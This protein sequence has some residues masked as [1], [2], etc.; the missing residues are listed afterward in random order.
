[1]NPYQK[2][3]AKAWWLILLAY[4]GATCWC[5]SHLSKFTVEAGTDVLLNEDDPDLAYYNE[6][7]TWWEYDEYIIVCCSRKSG[8]FNR[9]AL[10]RFNALCKDLQALPY[11]KTDGVTSITTIPLLR[12]KPPRGFLPDV[13]RMFDPKTREYNKDVD[14]A[15]AEKELLAHT[16]ALGNLISKN[17]QDVS[18]I[19]YLKLPE[20]INK[21]EPR[22]QRLMI[23]HKKKETTP[24]RRLAIEREL[25]EEVEPRYQAAK[26]VL[27]REREEFVNAVRDVARK[28][29]KEFDEPPRLAGLS[30]VNISL[31]EHI[32]ADLRTF[33]WLSFAF[34]ALTYLVIYRRIRWLVL[35]II[36]CVIPVVIILGSMSATGRVVTVIT[37]NLP[38]LLFVLMLP[39][40][41]Y[42]V[43]RYLERRSNFPDESGIMTTTTAPMAI[44]TP[45]LYSCT[46]TMAGTAS[47]MTSGISPVRTF[48]MMMTI[49]MALGLAT[50]M[51]LLPASTVPLRALTATG[52]GAQ[53][54]PIAPMRPLV[55]AVLRIP[56]VIILLSLAILGV[57]VWGT[58]KLN[59]ET[60]FIDYFW[61]K[62]EI[63]RGLDYIDN[64]MGGTVTVEVILESDMK[65]SLECE[66]CARTLAPEDLDTTKKCKA[67]GTK[68]KQRPGFFETSEGLATIDEVGKFFEKVPE[69]GNLRSFKTFVDEARKLLPQKDEMV[70]RSLWGLARAESREFLSEDFSVSRVIVRMKET[71]PTL[72]RNRILR[73]LA[74]HLD[75]VKRN[76]AGLKAAQPTGIFLLYANMLNSLIQSQ[77]DTFAMVVAAIWVMLVVLF[78]Q[79]P[80]MSKGVSTAFG[81]AIFALSAVG[82]WAYLAFVAKDSRAIFT[83][84]ETAWVLK[85]LA[86][87]LAA[88][89]VAAVCICAARK[90]SIVRWTVGTAALPTMVLLPQ[91]LPV[92]LVLGVMGFTGIPLDM[93]TVMIASMAMG[94]GID[95]AIQYTV[96]FRIELAATNGDI[97]AAIK[98]SHA[99]IGRSIMIATSIVF[100]G[101]AILAFSQF[102]PTVYF[103]LFTGLAMLMGLFGSLTTLPSTFVLLKY[104]KH[105]P[106]A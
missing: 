34:F 82:V 99:T 96:R 44:W 84:T 64:R 41:V 105:T 9:E 72:N 28:W 57:S 95:A 40:S 49:G 3:L 36:A 18:A 1:M 30:H 35:P 54:E 21:Y 92:F 53:S 15:K 98:R 2:L 93:V 56:L 60:K 25:R 51:L 6:T 5:F 63:Y 89:F 73:D 19:A 106:P 32:R 22:R 62:S 16:Q 78:V 38:I 65:R 69:T 90:S 85:W 101:F 29:E 48:G 66:K 79:F 37:S 31:L 76:H 24:E 46:T 39:Y 75:D 77:K 4:A 61:P 58:T 103:G 91:L 80:G 100:A 102:V 14:L 42:F 70:A 43:E 86:I 97:P 81:A 20:D 17:G 33:G 68:P 26:K 13:V 74:R 7:R 45:C 11:T 50:I 55:A 8:W 67:C 12:N 94:V 59:V 10:E 47:L 27:T 83:V 88:L 23:E 71:A 87:S 104:P 52:H